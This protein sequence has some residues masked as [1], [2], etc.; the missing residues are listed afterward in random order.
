VTPGPQTAGGAPAEVIAIVNTPVLKFG[1]LTLQ[2]KQRFGPHEAELLEECRRADSVN[3]VYRLIELRRNEA[4]AER[5]REVAADFILP[6]KQQ[7]CV[8]VVVV[9]AFDW[10]TDKLQ[11]L[12]ACVHAEPNDREYARLL[13]SGELRASSALA[14]VL[15]CF[16]CP[17]NS[18][19]GREA[20]VRT[21]PQYVDALIEQVDPTNARRLI[22]RGVI[23]IV[24]GFQGFFLDESTGRED[25]AILGR[26][27]SNLTAVAIAD[28]L[29][30]TECTMLTNVDGLYDKDPNLHPDARKIEAIGAVELLGWHPFPQV[31]QREA[32][33]YACERQVDIWI[34]DGFDP[35]LPGT[36]ITCRD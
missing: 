6:L 14:M 35:D 33:L 25:V 15:E 11:Q 24:A 4:R 5:L 22:E 32:V 27:G 29:G 30:Q 7:G 2:G 26:G 13:M 34:R 3:G 9:S 12:A 20:G 19:T 16:D 1:G 28:A 17:A 36:R 18:L 8:P 10:A 23:P 31:I 21:T